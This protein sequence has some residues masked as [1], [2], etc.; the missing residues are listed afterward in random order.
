MTQK[1]AGTIEN[2]LALCLLG[3]LLQVW[4]C[5]EPTPIVARVGDSKPLIDASGGA[6]YV[7]CA[8]ADSQGLTVGQMKPGVGIFAY[9]LLSMGPSGTPRMSPCVIGEATAPVAFHFLPREVLKRSAADVDFYKSI[10]GQEIQL[11]GVYLGA[12]GIQQLTV[13][14]DDRRSPETSSPKRATAK[15]SD[16]FC[17]AYA[18]RTFGKVGFQLRAKPGNT[19][20]MYIDYLNFERKTR[21][22]NGL[23]QKRVEHSGGVLTLSFKDFHFIDWD[24]GRSEPYSAMGKLVDQNFPKFITISQDG[25]ISARG[26]LDPVSWRQVDCPTEFFADY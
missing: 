25:S 20:H 22:S 23:F 9:G 1:R 7:E 13:A 17:I 5:G 19:A 18:D 24:G 16:I 2:G 3:L 12:T 11:R 26:S 21:K 8:V 15:A 4:S 14:A 10:E 6:F